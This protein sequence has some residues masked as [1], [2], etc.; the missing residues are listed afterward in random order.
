MNSMGPCAYDCWN[1]TDTGYCKT[2]GCINPAYQSVNNMAI[3]KCG[4]EWQYCDGNCSECPRVHPKIVS[5]VT[6]SIGG[7]RW[8]MK[9]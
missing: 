3:R 2:T 9:C 1:K 8:S 4:D 5:D 7:A 6:Y